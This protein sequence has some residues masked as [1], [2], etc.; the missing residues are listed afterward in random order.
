MRLLSKHGHGDRLASFLY[1]A[2]SFHADVLDGHTLWPE[3]EPTPLRLRVRGGAATSV[4]ICVA[5]L[6]IWLF[7][8]S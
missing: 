5:L 4:R 7:R 2:S 8:R 3:G 1:I 6:V